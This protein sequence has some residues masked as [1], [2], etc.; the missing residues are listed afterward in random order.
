LVDRDD[1]PGRPRRC[2]RRENQEQCQDSS[3]HR[4]R[5][6]R[7]LSPRAETCQD[8]VMVKKTP[9]IASS[10]ITPK[11]LYLNRR[12]F[13]QA[14]GIGAAGAWTGAL[15][16]PASAAGEKLAVTKRVVTT[17]DPPSP[18]QTITTF[19]NFYEFG[20]DKADPAKNSKNFKPRPWS[21]AVE[22]ACNKPGA[23]TL[24]DILK[25]HALEER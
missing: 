14:A 7:R 21:V 2:V 15:S 20:T 22:G 23:Y 6:S 17:T 8:L 16:T 4:H 18:Q 19:N 24:E 3:L 10:D 11:Q 25:P 1:G 9:A 12:E 5:T 13:L